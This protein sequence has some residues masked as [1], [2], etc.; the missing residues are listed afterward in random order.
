MTLV[1]RGEGFEYREMLMKR[2]GKGGK[3]YR[4]KENN[5]FLIYY[6]KKNADRGQENVLNLK[7]QRSK[8]IIIFQKL[9]F[10]N[11]KR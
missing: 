11:V 2:E 7:T 4:E 5:V 8:K 6:T 1:H 9:F 3:M 10:Y